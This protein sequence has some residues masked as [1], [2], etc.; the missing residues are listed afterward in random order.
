MKI[1][2]VE[3]FGLDFLNF[4]L[5]LV[6]YLEERGHEVYSIVPDDKYLEKVKAAGIRVLSFPLKKNTLNPVSFLRS[7]KAIRKFQNLHGFSVVHSFRLQPNIIT[8]LALGYKRKVKIVNHITGLGFA[9]AGKNP[10]SFFYRG[11]ILF[12]YQISFIFTNRI[13]VQNETDLRIISRLAFTRSKLMLLE[14]S[15][16]DRNRFSRSNA[17]MAIVESLRERLGLRPG[18][19]VVTF[20]GRLLREKGILEFLEVSNILSG[21]SEKMKF[22]IAGWFDYMNPS[23]LSRDELNS[24]LLDRRILFLEECSEIRELLYL[25]D[26]FVLPTYREGFPRS[27]LEAMSMELPVVTTRVPGAMDAVK[28]GINGLLVPPRDVTALENAITA[29]SGD[30]GLRLK[31][32]A[33]GVRFVDEKLSTDVIFRK[34][35]DIYESVSDAS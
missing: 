12:L 30:E 25:T 23:C 10:S 21:K 16:I 26:I 17:D 22:V 32:G 11:L 6:K 31:L 13:I 4:R 9:F 1:A 3:N 24:Y 35:L 2:L 19:I 34:I 15:G 27:V 29:L 7:A 5:P 14:G 18:D 28:D 20:T 33:N 8:S